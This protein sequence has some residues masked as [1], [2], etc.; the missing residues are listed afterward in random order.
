MDVCSKR[1]LKQNN[2]IN[3]M[4]TISRNK[5]LINKDAIALATKNAAKYANGTQIRKMRA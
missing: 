3:K 5:D 2:A 1:I 4:K